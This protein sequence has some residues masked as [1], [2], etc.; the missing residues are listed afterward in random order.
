MRHK[1]LES[2]SSYRLNPKNGALN[3]ARHTFAYDIVNHTLVRPSNKL[4]L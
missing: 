4:S 2:L 1:G 3:V